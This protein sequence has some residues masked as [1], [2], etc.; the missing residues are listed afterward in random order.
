VA[1]VILLAP[2]LRAGSMPQFVVSMLFAR[3]WGSMVWKSYAKTLWPG[4]EPEKAAERAAASTT[5][6][7]R[8]GRWSAFQATVKGLDHSV[9]TPWLP[10]VKNVPALVVVGDKD[11][12][13]SKPLEELDWIKTN[14]TTCTPLALEGVGHAPQLER[15]EV[16][17]KAALEFLDGLREKGAF[18]SS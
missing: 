1:G 2:F 5:S 15:P 13:W 14:F 17:G 10:S 18:A 6:M 4:L 11:P 16:V 8:P 12:D 9:V 3:P 7:T